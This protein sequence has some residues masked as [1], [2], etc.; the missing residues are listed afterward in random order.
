MRTEPTAREIGVHSLLIDP[1]LS[2]SAW[3][4]SQLATRLD[5]GRNPRVV[6]NP[7]PLQSLGSEA[8]AVAF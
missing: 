6:G 2:C 3:R 7:A 1:A 8:G 4:S 5:H